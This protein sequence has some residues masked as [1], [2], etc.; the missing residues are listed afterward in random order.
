MDPDRLKIVCYAGGTCGD[1]ISAM[2]DSTHARFQNTTV[3]HSTERQ[4]LKKPHTFSNDEEKDQYINNISTQYLSIPSHD[5]DYHVRRS[6]GF[7]SITV[8][9][10]NVAMWAARRFR[11]LH[12]PHVWQEMQTAC[13]ASSTEDYAQLLIDYSNMVVNHTMDV[14][15]L[16]DIR[17][18]HALDALSK[19]GINSQHKNL[20]HNWLDLQNHTF[21]I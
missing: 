19:L 1:L 13:G 4:R 15:K 8:Q 16:E 9:D 6:H 21:L 11:G 20:Y 17:N 10:F 12:R 7:I 18:G 14:V 5:L 3:I 2:I